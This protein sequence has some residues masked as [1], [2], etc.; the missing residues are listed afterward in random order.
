MS[1]AFNT[2]GK[3]VHHYL[4][5]DFAINSWEDLKPYFDE[6]NNRPLQTLEELIK[7]LEDRSELDSAIQE[8]FAWRYIRMSCDTSNELLQKDYTFFV[9]E[10]EPL[11]S[12]ED[13][14]LNE[15][16]LNTPVHSALLETDYKNY[17]RSVKKRVEI[18]RQE[19]V[20]LQA[21]LQD[22]QQLF[23][24]LSGAQ[25]IDYNGQEMTL[26]QA[27]AMLKNTDRSLR[28][29]IYRKIANRRL[30]DKEKL[31]SLYSSLILLR[32]K[33]A[34]N[35][36]FL[37]YRDYA[38]VALN[39]FDYNVN[40]CITFHNSIQSE[41]IPLTIQLDNSRK[42]AL[43]YDRLKPWDMAVDTS[44]KAPVQPFKSAEELVQKTINCLHEIDEELASCIQLLNSLNRFDLDSRKGK[45]PGGYNY[46]LY[47]TG[48]PFIFMNS[49]GQMRDLVTMVH[50]S[51]HAVHAVL[52]H[53]L[54]FH[55]FKSCPSEV[56]ELASM[57]MELITM[58]HW[59]HFIPDQ[60][61]LRRAKL[62]HLTS[63]I[64]I[65]PWIATVDAFQHWVY[66]N[67][68]H[69][70][71]EREKNWLA[72]YEK[73]A[74]PV[75]DWSGFEEVKQNTWQKQIHIFDAPFYYIEYGMAQLGAIAVWKNYKENPKLAIQQYKQAL[76]LGYTRSISEIY[77][78]AG[79]KFDFSVSYIRELIGF[80]TKEIAIIST[81]E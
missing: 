4:K 24:Q 29:T 6:L 5:N 68:L 73:F 20:S 28:E 15:K 37:N 16:L 74:S 45:S 12:P 19:N 39:R 43:G 25:T 17:L 71:E 9:R 13:N 55:E 80:L 64:E 79:A 26:Q 32:N 33:I 31:D 72:I 57:A 42:K 76:Q 61:E 38:F 67:P 1:I 18:F 48:V 75:I 11:I 14:K 22:K 58:E 78:T 53:P 44:G 7:W 60:S 50:E 63:I 8:N 59:H 51:G 65:L 21:E 56:A 69:S 66:E 54:T 47:E 40:D 27:A 81:T 2:I 34:K 46:P 36:G 35:A 30:E 62:E 70:V 52:T 23:G 10:I 77:E 3:V 49:T 41:I